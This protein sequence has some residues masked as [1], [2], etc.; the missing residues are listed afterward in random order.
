MI[1]WQE[2]Q[3]FS[4]KYNAIQKNDKAP[5][6]HQFNRNKLLKLDFKI[7]I[8]NSTSDSNTYMFIVKN[9]LLLNRIFTFLK[10]CIKIRLKT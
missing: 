4:S 8:T 6:S 1:A 3:V 10:C 9:P 2:M 5:A 7:L